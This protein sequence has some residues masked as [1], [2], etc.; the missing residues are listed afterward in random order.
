M[1]QLPHLHG[2]QVVEIQHIEQIE[3]VSMDWAKK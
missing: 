3:M 2:R 1:I